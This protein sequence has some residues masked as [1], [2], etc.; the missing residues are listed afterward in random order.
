MHPPT[1]LVA[2]DEPSFRSLFR[3]WLE[4]AGFAVRLASDGVEA[5]ASITEEGLPDAVVLD[6]NMPRLDGVD[7]CRILRRAEPLLPVVI[8]SADDDVARI[9]RLAGAS[10]ALAKPSTP[11][12]L[13]GVLRNLLSA[14]ATTVYAA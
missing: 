1:V 12:E 4:G 8:V 6:V 7:L 2:E 11:N 5:L 9:G 3:V 10:A 14:P 13:I